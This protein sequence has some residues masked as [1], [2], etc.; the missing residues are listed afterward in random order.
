MC[1]TLLSVT[2]YLHAFNIY[3]DRYFEWERYFILHNIHFIKEPFKDN[4]SKKKQ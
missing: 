2:V 3:K 4:I 1:E